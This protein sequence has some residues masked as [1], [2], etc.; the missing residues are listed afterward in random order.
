MHPSVAA[1]L[2][3]RYAQLLDAM[4][5]RDTETQQWQ[6]CARALYSEAGGLQ[7]SPFSAAEGQ[8]SAIDDAFGDLQQLQGKGSSGRGALSDVIIRRLL[9]NA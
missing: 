8:S 6:S 2:A 7:G 4:P 1:Q 3:W 9:P 5:K